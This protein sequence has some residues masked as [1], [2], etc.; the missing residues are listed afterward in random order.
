MEIVMLLEVGYKGCLYVLM[1][2]HKAI[3]TAWLVMDELDCLW[4]PIVK[5]W[6]LNER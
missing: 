6:R 1:H 2:L 3:E 5:S 4:L